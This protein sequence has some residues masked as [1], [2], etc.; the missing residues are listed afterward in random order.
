MAKQGKRMQRI[1]SLLRQPRNLLVT[2]LFGN[3]LVNIASTSAVTALAINLLGEEGIG[4]AVL[5]MTFLIL[6]FGEIMPKSLAVKKAETFAV[7]AVPLLVFFN[8]L[9]YPARL[10]LGAVAEFAVD[11][12]R[13]LF[14]ESRKEY[15]PRELATAV[16]AGH[17]SGLFDEFEK[18]LLKNLFLFT[19]VTVRESMT[20]RVD[21]FSLDEETWINDAAP[22]VRSRGFSR[23]PIYGGSE[24]NIVG[25]L[26][27][28]DLLRHGR[29]EK[30]KLGMIMREAKFVPESKPIRD[31]LGELVGAENHMIVVVDEHGSFTGILTLEDI[32]EEIFG[33]IRNR[34]QL[35]V[36]DYMLIDEEHIVVEGSMKLDEIND[37]FEERLESREVETV[38]GYLTEE[39]GKIPKEGESFVL[40]NLRFL[41]ISSD[42]TKVSKIKIE[43]LGEQ[44]GSNGDS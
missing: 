27:S 2:I 9:F 11:R 34:H 33:E 15:G 22:R 3:I 36:T 43:K 37:I 16:E 30:V 13:V 8:M 25:I 35:K 17:S 20:P 6:I 28:R 18:G 42:A 38:A 1:S 41:V 44:G 10:V 24:D 29:D 19:E 21:V 26:F 12:S 40:G 39:I 7:N 32:L 23:I 14:G 5:V 31:L 4:I